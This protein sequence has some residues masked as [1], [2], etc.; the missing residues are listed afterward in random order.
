MDYGQAASTN[1]ISCVDG[2]Y[3]DN[4]KLM[5]SMIEATDQALAQV[6]VE[7]GVMFANPDG[8]YTF[9]K[10]SN[11]VRQA[12]GRGAGWHGMDLMGWLL[13]RASCLGVRGRHHQ[14]TN[15]YLLS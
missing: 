4:W 13:C 12:V 7:T 15:P 8:S 14:G 11:T 2:N 6:L 10:D 1:G 5:N 9:N 3:T